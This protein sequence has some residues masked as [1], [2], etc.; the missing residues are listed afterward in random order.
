MNQGKGEGEQQREKQA[1]LK[2]AELKVSLREEIGQGLVEVERRNGKVFITVGSGGTFPSG[3]ADI[4][5]AARD[6]VARI[7]FASMGEA[8]EIKVVGH[9]D[10]VPISSGQ[11]RDNWD[12][13]G[14]RASAVVREIEAMGYMTSTQMEAISKGESQ[15]VAD[16]DTS[17]GR[18]KNR[19]IE[20]EI[21]YGDSE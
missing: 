14:A 4:T 19:R 16:N 10:N 13:A 5:E 21:T 20:I 6:I 15:P 8:S 3:S 18:E 12:L 17:E 11:F 7:S 9:T 1:E 2:E